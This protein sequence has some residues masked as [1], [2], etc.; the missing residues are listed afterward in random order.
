MGQ[1]EFSK[2]IYDSIPVSSRFAIVQAYHYISVPARLLLETKQWKEC[3]NIRNYIKLPTLSFEFQN[4]MRYYIESVGAFFLKDVE[5]L[6]RT[7][8]QLKEAHVIYVNSE[9][10]KIENHPMKQKFEIQMLTGTPLLVFLTESKSKGIEL[11][12]VVADKED[13]FD[14]SSINPAPIFPAREI[15]AQMLLENNQLELVVKELK[16][17]LKV[18]NPNR[19]NAFYLLGKTL[20]SLGDKNQAIVYFKKVV[21]LCDNKLKYC[22]FEKPCRNYKCNER[23][24]MNEAREI[25]KNFQK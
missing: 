9:R 2:E 3:L 18:E 5:T 16:E 4:V 17:S 11:M 20:L 24:E 1:V 14:R 6:K 10:Y 8:V 13:E 15:L 19:L 12:K 22:N 25:I 7:V 23:S 21:D